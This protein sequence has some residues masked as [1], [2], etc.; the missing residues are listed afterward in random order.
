MQA[1]LNGMHELVR[2]KHPLKIIV[3]GRFPEI[4]KKRFSVEIEIHPCYSEEK[5]CA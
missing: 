3:Y 4:W 1:F 5:W 2:R